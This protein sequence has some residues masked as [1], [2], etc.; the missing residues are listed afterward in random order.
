MPPRAT[1]GM[2]QLRKRDP[3]NFRFTMLQ[4][5][6]P[7]MEADDVLRLEST[8]KERLHTRQPFGLNDN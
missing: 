4:R 7:D 2:T 3:K 8:W 1:A 5:V 6:S